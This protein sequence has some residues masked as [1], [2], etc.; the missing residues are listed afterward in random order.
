[1]VAMEGARRSGW[2]AC[3]MVQS[4]VD[5]NEDL[6]SEYGSKATAELEHNR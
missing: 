5:Q 3:Q 1:M 2:R 4:L 6:D